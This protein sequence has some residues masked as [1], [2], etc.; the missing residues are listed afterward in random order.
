MCKEEDVFADSIIC[1]VQ[2]S[3]REVNF[4][5]GLRTLSL[6]WLS[7]VSEIFKVE[8]NIEFTDNFVFLVSQSKQAC[9]VYLKNKEGM[10][11]GGVM[12]TESYQCKCL[13]VLFLHTIR[14]WKAYAIFFRCC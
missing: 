10:Q 3:A 11:Y 4:R 6:H 13:L 9:N 1:G 7:S 14:N 12:S 2:P 5:V 8:L